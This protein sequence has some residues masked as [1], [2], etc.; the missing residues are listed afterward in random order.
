MSS[1][2]FA[3][4]AAL[5]GVPSALAAARD[6]VDAILRDRGRRASTPEMTAESLLIGAAASAQ[7]AGSGTDLDELR[8][9]R[10]DE[11]AA[12]AARLNAGLLALVPVIER[13]PLQAFARLHTLVAVGRV[14][15]ESLG[16]PRTGSDGAAQ[17]Q[18]LG[19][20]LVRPTNA[21]AL[22]VAALAHAEIATSR[23]FEEGNDLVARALERLLI[24]CRGVDPASVLVPEAGHVARADAYHAALQDYASNTRSGRRAWLLYAADAITDSLAASPLSRR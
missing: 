13:A 21:P 2:L 8:A 17:L 11:I 9:G 15:Q 6:G 20:L 5:E 19:A 14:E 18:R 4:L 10:G 1:D 16:R 23:P 12:A 22:A 7:L 24:V 3:E